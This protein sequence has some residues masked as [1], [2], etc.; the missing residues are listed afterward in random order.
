MPLQKAL[1]AKQEMER[2]GARVELCT[3]P[4]GHKLGASCL[5]RFQSFIGTEI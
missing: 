3:S 4:V 1:S 2:L 5:R